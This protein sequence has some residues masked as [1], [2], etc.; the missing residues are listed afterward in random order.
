MTR[1]T[2]TGVLPLYAPSMS[3]ASLALNIPPSAASRPL[4][5]LATDFCAPARCALTCARHLAHLRGAAVRALHVMDLTSA[6]TGKRPS[7][8]V[9]EASA[10]SRL[11]DIRHELRL[12]GLPESATLV[13]AGRPARAIRQAAAECHASLLILGINGARSRKASTLGATAHALLS[14]SPCPVLTVAPPC[15]DI[16]PSHAQPFERPLFVT[17][18]APGSAR[19]A[20]DAWPGLQ[21]P[22]PI[23]V[24]LPP[25]GEHPLKLDPAIPR[26]FASPRMIE[27]PGAAVTLLRESASARA[28][29]I[30]LA[31]RAG[32]YLDSFVTGSFAHTLVTEAPCPVLTVRC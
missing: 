22:P 10:E 14:Q 7:Y 27:L 11:R 17:D 24:V 30:V 12:A 31:L 4:I 8:S 29:L 15:P 20:L 32:S 19:A 21:A 1:I 16:P 25:G 3:A 18:T 5:L 2:D 23:R 6:S 28:G 26:R 13:T 9:A